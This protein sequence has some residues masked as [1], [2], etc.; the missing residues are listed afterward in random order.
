MKGKFEARN[1]DRFIKTVQSANK[2]KASFLVEG[3]WY[4]NNFRH[5]RKS[6]SN[7]ELHYIVIHPSLKYLHKAYLKRHPNSKKK[8]NNRLDWENYDKVILLPGLNNNTKLLKEKTLKTTEIGDEGI[9][10]RVKKLL[11][12]LNRNENIKKIY[13]ITGPNVSGKST[14]FFE[15]FKQIFNI[16]SEKEFKEFVLE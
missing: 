14:L 10:E 13:I 5:L 11:R 6:L 4:F 16:K 3:G 15:L 9:K 12:I 2:S 7:Y 8:L 1:R